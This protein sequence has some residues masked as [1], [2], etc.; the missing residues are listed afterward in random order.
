MKVTDWPD[1]RVY[2]VGGGREH[3]WFA[4][5]WWDRSGDKRG[6]SNSGFYVRGFGVPVRETYD[7]IAPIVFEFA[8]S[9]WPD[10]IGRQAFP[11][12]L[13]P[14][15]ARRASPVGTGRAGT[16]TLRLNRHGHEQIL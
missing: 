10:V 11:L 4:F 1:G 8:C 15:H 9:Q 12:V 13:Q 5:V 3:F 7:A 2:T 14:L 6:A 16:A